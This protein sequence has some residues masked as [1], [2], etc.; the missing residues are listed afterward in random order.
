[1]DKAKKIVNSWWFKSTLFLGTGILLWISGRPLYAGI[2][3]GAGG[4]ELMLAFKEPA[5][6]NCQC[7]GCRCEKKDQMLKS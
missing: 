3:F 2:A 4:R 6:C 1:M 5:E 7:K